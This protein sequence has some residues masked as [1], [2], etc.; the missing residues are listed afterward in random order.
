MTKPFELYSEKHG[1]VVAAF[2]FLGDTDKIWYEVVTADGTVWQH[3][4]GER[5]WDWYPYTKS[6]AKEES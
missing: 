3:Y 2:R 1:P 6:I 5:G 4:Q